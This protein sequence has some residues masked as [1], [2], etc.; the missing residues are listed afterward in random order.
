MQDFE[1]ILKDPIQ[2]QLW[3]AAEKGD[4]GQIRIAIVNGADIDARDDQGRTARNIASQ[5][6]HVEALKTLT[7]AKQMMFFAEQE[8]SEEQNFIQKVRKNNKLRS[9]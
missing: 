6:G 5:Y 9:A 2:K 3:Q 7:A 8:G 1:Q 4:C